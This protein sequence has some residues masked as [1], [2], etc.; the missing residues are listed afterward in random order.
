MNLHEYQSKQRVAQYAI[1]IPKGEV[2]GS[3]AAAVAAARKRGGW[4]WVM[5]PQ[6]HAGA[7]PRGGQ[8]HGVRS[9]GRL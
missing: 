5:K 2:A 3:P 7:H 1:P 4:L 9:R 8:P 6:V